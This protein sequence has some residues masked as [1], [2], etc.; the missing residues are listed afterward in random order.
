MIGEYF[1]R[2]KVYFITVSSNEKSDL[3]H[4]R[5]REREKSKE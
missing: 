1:A 2:N 5:E 3:K 4:G